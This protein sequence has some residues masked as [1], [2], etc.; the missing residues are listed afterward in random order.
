MEYDNFET[1]YSLYPRKI[2]RKKA[3]IAFNRLTKKKQALAIEDVRTRY[4]GADKQ[5]T[6]HPTTYI[7]GELWNDEKPT[8]D[9]QPIEVVEL[10]ICNHQG[11]LKPVHGPN[12][13]NCADHLASNENPAVIKKMRQIY[14]DNDLI[15]REGETD[16]EHT[17]RLRKTY[18]RMMVHDTPVKDMDKYS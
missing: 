10:P 7:N 12:Y 4:K 5:Y 18:V 3:E 9:S 13:P 8:D 1:F 15:Q 11:C 6:P 2:G 16:K 17:L 14:K